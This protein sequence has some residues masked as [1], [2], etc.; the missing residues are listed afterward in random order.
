MGV[1]RALLVTLAEPST[2]AWPTAQK[3]TDPEPPAD[4]PIRYLRRDPRIV[5]LPPIDDS[6][7]ALIY[8]GEFP[9]WDDVFEY[10]STIQDIICVGAGDWVSMGTP[11]IQNLS[12][13]AMRYRTFRWFDPDHDHLH[14]YHRRDAAEALIE[15]PRFRGT[16]SYWIFHGFTLREHQ[17]GDVDM[18]DDAHDIVFSQ[19]WI[20]RPRRHYVFRGRSTICRMVV[21]ECLGTDPNWPTPFV[22]T[23][24]VQLVP[25]AGGIEECLVLDCESRNFVDDIQISQDAVLPETPVE[26]QCASMDA[27]C[28]EE[29]YLPGGLA[30]TENGA[31]FKAGSDAYQI[32]FSDFRCWGKRKNGVSSLGDALEIHRHARNILFL[33]PVIWDCPYGLFETQWDA[34]ISLDTPRDI[35]VQDGQFIDIRAYAP[36]TS[37]A[38]SIF[39]VNNNY[40][41][42]DCWFRDCDYVVNQFAVARA[43]GPV[44]TGCVRI[45]TQ[46]LHPLSVANPWVEGDNSVDAASPSRPY[47]WIQRRRWT[48]P[49]LAMGSALDQAPTT[50]P[51]VALFS[52]E[53]TGGDVDFT[54]QSSAP[55]STIVSWA[56]TFGDGGSSTSQHPSHTYA[57]NGFYSI[58][59]TITDDNAETATIMRNIRI[60][61]LAGGRQMPTWISMGTHEAGVG[62]ITP[63]LPAGRIEGDYLVMKTESQGAAPTSLSSAQGFVELDD[64]PIDSGQAAGS[65]LGLFARFVGDPA[66]EAL[67]SAPTV[68]DSG[69][70][71]QGVIHCLRGVDPTTPIHAIATAIETNSVFDI[72]LPSVVTSEDNC[73]ILG[74]ATTG[75][76][77]ADPEFSGIACPS[78]ANLTVRFNDGTT[79]GNGG[80]LLLVTGERGDYGAVQPMTVVSAHEQR[81]CMA[82][83]ALLGAVA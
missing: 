76:D 8:P 28:T 53:V 79:E 35:V 72:A 23:L 2:F 36:D 82:T 1:G 45:N 40:Q 57:A 10:Y 29:V 38:G 27:Y 46:V 83:I 11:N 47:Q 16:S 75:Q 63:G 52:F 58:R 7:R 39:R 26:V 33:R 60:T 6:S 22:D 20:D 21:Q 80:G 49:E 50:R 12:G 71:T 61:G 13:T 5:P 74:I 44:F 62:T 66:A 65:S 56:W 64:S 70:H 73:L 78:L 34:P 17:L 51:P 42:V 41:I 25:D 69:N 43:G 3:P 55:D 18:F 24:F 48:G 19:L 9:S 81:F 37:G 30:D 4:A 31:D 15:A 14:P 59:L 68:A 67:L 54:D 77:S 32:V